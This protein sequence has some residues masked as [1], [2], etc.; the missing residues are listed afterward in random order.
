[1][2]DTRVQLEVEDWVR[3]NWM[4]NQFGQ[5]FFRNRLNLSSGG[6]F[7]F[8][9]VSTD[10]SVAACIASSA[11]KTSRGKLG[12]GKLHKV[13]SDMLFLHL[14]AGLTRKLMI[15]TEQDMH[16]VCLKEKAGG[17]VPN[18]IEFHLA[19]IPADLHARLVKAR[20]AASREV[21]QQKVEQLPDE[22]MLRKE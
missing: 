21:T 16:E 14:A 10:K 5:T 9:A 17:R 6:V 11:G 13:R 20:E 18:D 4:P 22:L 3:E 7:D 19:T 2:A 12:V 15:L 8:D 1:M